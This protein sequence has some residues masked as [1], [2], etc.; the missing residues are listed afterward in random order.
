MIMETVFLDLYE[1]G[2]PLLGHVYVQRVDIPMPCHFSPEAQQREPGRNPCL[3]LILKNLRGHVHK[4]VCAVL[5]V[6]VRR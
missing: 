2:C 4:T 6:L 1:L 5:S 3:G